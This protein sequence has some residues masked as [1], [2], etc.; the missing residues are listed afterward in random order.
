MSDATSTTVPAAGD[1]AAKY[2]SGIRGKTVLTTGASPASIGGFFLQAIAAHEPA[3]LILAGRS[4]E[5]LA[6]TAAAIAA[7][8]P[9]VQTR[10]LKIDL[11]SLK[12]VRRAAAELL[13]WDDVPVVDVLVNN[14]GIMAT[15]YARSEEGVESQMATNH[16]SH[17]L[18]ANLIMSKL[19]KSASPRVV[20]VTST[21]HRMGPIRWDDLNFD[22]GETY[23]KWYAYGQSKTANMLFAISLAEKLG[24][25]GLQ[26]Y[27]V[28]PGV[29]LGTGLGVHLDL[30]DDGDLPQLNKLDRML[31]NAEGWQSLNLI[32]QEQGAATHVFAAFDNDLKEYNGAYLLECRRADPFIDTVKVWATSSSEAERLWKLSEKLVGQEF[33]Y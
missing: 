4:D 8:H 30:S 27:S 26:A 15:P 32:T 11:S 24:R 25:R 5:K 13:S 12:D 10:R 28:H 6:A 29:I 18:F 2:A 21:G 17:F 23:N 33:A 19:L 1:L 16:L 22:N 3:L 7:T 14:A 31:G 9:T 20:S